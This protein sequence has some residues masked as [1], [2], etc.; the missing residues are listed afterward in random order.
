MEKTQQSSLD[1]K[2]FS[3]PSM[4]NQVVGFL[5]DVVVGVPIGVALRGDEDDSEEAS[6]SRRLRGFQQYAPLQVNNVIIFFE[7]SCF[8]RIALT[9]SSILFLWLSA[10]SSFS[11]RLPRVLTDTALDLSNLVAKFDV[12]EE[13]DEA[14]AA[15]VRPFVAILL[16]SPPKLL[17]SSALAIV[18][19]LLAEPRGHL[20]TQASSQWF[21]L[22]DVD[23]G[24]TSVVSIGMESAGLQLNIVAAMEW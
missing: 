12:A 20:T 1:S 5:S 4:S 2:K 18:A 9:M 15:T 14:P 10:D 17:S 24:S 19:S 13:E 7:A 21:S 11:S 3:T 23:I 6:L 8:R 22:L 16:M